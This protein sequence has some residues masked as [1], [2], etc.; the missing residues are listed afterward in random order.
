MDNKK[1]L[2][3]Q[4]FFFIPSCIFWGCVIYCMQKIS[5]KDGFFYELYE[6]CA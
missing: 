3:R 6:G 1:R 2:P 4:S 5:E